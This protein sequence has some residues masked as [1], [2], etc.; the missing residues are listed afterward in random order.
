[1][2]RFFHP[3]L[4][5][6]ASATHRELAAQVSYL[7]AENEILR[8]KLPKRVTV[9]DAEKARL[10]KLGTKVGSAIRELITIVSP[11]TFTRWVNGATVKHTT[12]R[13]KPGRPRTEQEIVD[14]VV[15]MAKDTGWG[16]TKI[17]FELRKLG[18][19]ICRTTVKNILV[20]HGFDPG[21]ERGEGSWDQFIKMHAKTLWACDFLSKKVLTKH[22]L[23]DYFVLVFIN[24][25]TRRVIATPATPNP[26]EEWVVQ[27]ARNVVMDIEDT[28]MK[29]EHLIH[30]WDTKFTAQFRGLFEYEGVEIH[31][32]GPQKPNQN[33]YVERWIQSCQQECLDHFIVLGEKHFNHLVGEYVEHF[34]T[35][36]P[37]SAIG[38]APCGTDPPTEPV[39]QIECHE[40]LGGL[41]R[42]YCRRAA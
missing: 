42:H 27:Q 1:M 6:L 37:H 13:R 4:R 20:S 21:P 36:R 40:R 16:Y 30:D 32:V 2:A 11:R 14:L 41:L 25:A 15:Q 9:T 26:N 28:G 31:R 38:R 39:G 34:N 7:K 12:P 17:L 3:L 10:V 19:K 35:E 5:V 8:S 22:G 33:A 24:I 29:I 23:I 18:I